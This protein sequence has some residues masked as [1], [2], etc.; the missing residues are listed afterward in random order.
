MGIIEDAVTW[1]AQCGLRG[2]IEAVGPSPI[3]VKDATCG[4]LVTVQETDPP[5][6]IGTARYNVAGKRSMWTLDGKGK[7]R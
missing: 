7:S 4:W 2:E 6:R 3:T 5:G 1:G